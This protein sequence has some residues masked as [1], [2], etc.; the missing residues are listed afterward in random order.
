MKL[1]TI[2][3]PLFVILCTSVGCTESNGRRW[4]PAQ[5]ALISPAQIAPESWDVYGLKTNFVFC[6]NHDFAGLGIGCIDVLHRADGVNVGLLGIT[7]WDASGFELS[8][9]GNSTVDEMT[10]LQVALLLNVVVRPPPEDESLSLWDTSELGGGLAAGSMRGAQI[11]V[12]WNAAREMSGAQVAGG[13]L[14]PVLPFLIPSSGNLVQGDMHGAQI[15]PLGVNVT[16]GTVHGLQMAGLGSEAER[17]RGMQ[18][19]LVNEVQ[20]RGSWIAGMLNANLYPREM[21]SR[22]GLG[23]ADGVQIGGICNL[24]RPPVRGVQIAGIFNIARDDMRGLQL[25]ALVNHTRRLSGVQIGLIN[26]NRD[27]WLPFFPLVNVGFSGHNKDQV[28]AKPAAPPPATPAPTPSAA[29][30]AVPD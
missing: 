16:L 27:G 24:V 3:F 9:L 14:L 11:S 20:L 22:S 15:S 23:G 1:A 28:E 21:E 13:T 2:L 5:V 4:S 19:G 30:P 18:I 12:L 17:L 29:M 7:S 8:G 10:G 6:R 25:S 26:I